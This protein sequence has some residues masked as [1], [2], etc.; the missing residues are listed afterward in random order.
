MSYTSTNFNPDG[1][2][3]FVGFLCTDWTSKYTD[4][5]LTPIN[6]SEGPTVTSPGVYTD[7]IGFTT[8]TTVPD[9]LLYYYGTLNN[10]PLYDSFGNQLSFTITNSS[11]STTNYGVFANIQL[12]SQNTLPALGTYNN[13]HYVTITIFSQSTTDVIDSKG[14]V[15]VVTNSNDTIW[16]NTQT[17][18]QNVGQPTFTSAVVT[19][20]DKKQTIKE[21][22]I[23][24]TILG[25]ANLT[26]TIL[27]AQQVVGGIAIP[28]AGDNITTS[29]I[30]IGGISNVGSTNYYS[31]NG[32][33]SQ[34]QPVSGYTNPFVSSTGPLFYVGST[35]YYYTKV[36]QSN[37]PTCGY[38]SFSLAST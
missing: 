14:N 26:S 37:M 25:Q 22:N 9:S 19:S 20:T 17:G 28:G 10:I 30:S 24:K 12:A 5:V 4:P 33:Y 8:L 27:Y 11:S 15:S 32:Y 35:T 2:G 38:F 1:S 16:L 7:N 23:E 3:N 21:G 18:A 31:W 6:G 36:G 29:G 13:S 34:N